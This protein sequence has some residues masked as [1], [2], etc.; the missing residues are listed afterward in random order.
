MTQ[1]IRLWE[2]SVPLAHDEDV[3]GTSTLTIFQPRTPRG[4]A[5]VIF[6]G[7]GYQALASH[8]GEEYAWFMASHG[9]TAAVCHY[10]HGRVGLGQAPL[11]DAKRAVRTVRHMADTLNIKPDRVAIM[12]SSAGGHLAAT[13][14][15]QFD[16]GQTDHADPIERQSSRPDSACLC[17]PVITMQKPF[18]HEG[19]TTNL[20]GESASDVERTSMSAET[21]VTPQ[22][23]PTFV[24][25]TGED[26]SVPIENAM[27]YAAALRRHGVRFEL[28]CYETGRHGLGLGRGHGS[29]RS[30][31][32]EWLKWLT[33][34]GW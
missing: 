2:G 14:S 7:G 31:S 6:P 25:H 4:S 21:R 18:A 26:A 23:P 27:S 22:T 19:S 24:W 32:D 10:R 28:H 13:L 8:E 20:L 30:W 1:H 29:V 33:A 15:T 12:G 9:I 3:P 16:L 34:H 11:L 5:V 17:Y